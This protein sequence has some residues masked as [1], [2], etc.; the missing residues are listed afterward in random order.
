M[1]YCSIAEHF[2]RYF[3][4]VMADTPE[5]KREVYSIR[6][7]VYC[8]ELS[9]ESTDKFPDGLEKD[10]YDDHSIH[11]LLKHRPSGLYAGCVRIVLPKLSGYLFDLPSETLFPHHF[12]LLNRPKQE[13]CEI[14]R[15]AVLS[16]FRKIDK[17][18][19]PLEGML[20]PY[21]EGSETKQK[22]LPIIALSLYWTSISTARSLNLDIAALMEPR[23]ARHLKRFGITSEKIGSLLN[24]RGKRGFFLIKPKELFDNL[25]VEI[26]DLYSL[27]YNQVETDIVNWRWQIYSQEIE[28]EEISL[29]QK[30]FLKKL[31]V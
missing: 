3:E 19:N 22:F 18:N 7:R 30:N 23:L 27:I 17:E 16:E 10:A 13:F 1:S 8:E 29:L 31:V 14:S 6:Y 24:Y 5:L 15:L 2:N 21:S 4:L 25:K 28:A 11:Y 20:I 9:Y 12:D 26:K